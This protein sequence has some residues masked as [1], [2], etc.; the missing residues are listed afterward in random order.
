MLSK[1]EFRRVQEERIAVYSLVAR[2]FE[3]PLE[4]CDIDTLAQANLAELPCDDAAMR[5]GLEVMGHF[6]RKRNSGTREALNRDYT[7]AFYGIQ[8]IGGRYALPY[9]SAFGDSSQL[10]MGAARRKVF[11]VYKKQALRL[12]EGV[13][14]PEDH[15]SYMCEFMG[16]MARKA[17][18]A[19]ER[20]DSDGVKESL[21]L[22]RAFLR[23]HILSWYEELELLAGQLV[24]ARFY[25]G[26]LEFAGAFFK[27]DDAALTVQLSDMGAARARFDLAWWE[28]P[29]SSD[30]RH[31][32]RPNL[33]KALC[34][35]KKGGSCDKCVAAC[36]VHIDPVLDRDGATRIDCTKCGKCVEACP[37]AALEIK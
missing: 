25:R 9:E 37:S 5:H 8:D 35:R 30:E 31:A 16:A 19:H 29:R 11:N 22:Q 12:R 34:I 23:A 33:D 13:D 1:E 10:L 2:L 14:I 3:C 6:L 36:P 18:D 27:L 28:A 26:V 24:E 17:A 15:L 20:G 21:L 32:Y 4:Q 7:S